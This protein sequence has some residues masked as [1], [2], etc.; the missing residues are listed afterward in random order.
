MLLF[1][2]RDQ[3]PRTRLGRL[4]PLAA[5]VIGLWLR[6]RWLR[7][8]RWRYGHEAMADATHEFHLRAARAMV[9]RAIRQQGLIIKTCQF[10]GSRADVLMDEY[11]RTLSL[12]HDQVPPRPWAEMRPIIERELGMTIE[13]AY[14]EFDPNP[15]AA[16]SLAQTGQ[17][18]LAHLEHAGEVELQ[19]PLP[20][21]QWHL[22]QAAG[23]GS[24][25]V[26]D[27]HAWG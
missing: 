5:T 9:H 3:P 21:I 13:E 27:H 23:V 26:V 6:W 12:V 10:L 25:G 4:V 20:L 19:E 17:H 16:A 7:V 22:R 11:V 8:L 1:A 18:R 2:R 15:I 24:A 14:A